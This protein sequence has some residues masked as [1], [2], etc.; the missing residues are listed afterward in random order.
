[1]LTVCATKLAHATDFS[2]GASTGQL[3]RAHL[4]TEIVHTTTGCEQTQ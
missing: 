4:E 3:G 2:L 1:M